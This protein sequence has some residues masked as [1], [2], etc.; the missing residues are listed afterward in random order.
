MANSLFK[1]S[2]ILRYTRTDTSLKL[3]VEI[4]KELTRYYRAL[5]PKYIKSSPQMYAPHI[6]LVRKE[7]PPNM[8]VWDKYE[9]QEID[10]FYENIVYFGDVYCWLNVF[11][12]RFEEIRAELGLRVES[13]YT[14]PPEGFVKCFHTTLGNFKG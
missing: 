8:E 9:G 11:S 1:S 5:I 3:V 10:F 7:I 6:S 12:K 2:G 4:D 13:I 14:L